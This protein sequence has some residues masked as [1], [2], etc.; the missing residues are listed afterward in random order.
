MN[1]NSDKEKTEQPTANQFATVAHA[2]KALAQLKP[3]I[4]DEQRIAFLGKIS[5]SKHP[6]LLAF[7]LLCG[8]SRKPSKKIKPIAVFEQDLRRIVQ[9]AAPTSDLPANATT[10]IL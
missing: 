7:Q 9:G 2:K 8:V 6:R 3:P 10:E 1:T 5:S 4:T